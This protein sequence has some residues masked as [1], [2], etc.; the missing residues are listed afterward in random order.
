MG[1]HRC[2][3]CGTEY[4]EEDLEDA[5]KFGL[6]A[7][8]D[9]TQRLDAGGLVPSGECPDPECGA[10]VYPVDPNFVPAEFERTLKDLVESKRF[11]R[12]EAELEDFF[13]KAQDLLDKYNY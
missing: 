8:P 13:K 1:R 3:N 11:G 10:L 12:P 7:I 4:E 6:D 2:D 9:L 5:G